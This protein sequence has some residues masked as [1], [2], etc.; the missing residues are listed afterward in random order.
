MK[1]KKKFFSKL[2][3]NKNHEKLV[4]LQIHSTLRKLELRSYVVNIYFYVWSIL[5][6]L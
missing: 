4:L 5:R 2:N 6:Q 1:N 3:G